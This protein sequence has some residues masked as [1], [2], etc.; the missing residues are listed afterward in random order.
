MSQEE[1]SRSLNTFTDVMTSMLFPRKCKNDTP[2]TLYHKF[3]RL[4]ALQEQKCHLANFPP[5]CPNSP[6]NACIEILA[7][8]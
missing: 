1:Q 4:V 5:T 3:L 2:V 6:H 7:R 8:R